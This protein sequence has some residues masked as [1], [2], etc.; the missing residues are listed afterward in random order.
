MNNAFIVL[1]LNEYRA[2]WVLRDSIAEATDVPGKGMGILQ[3]LQKF[4]V[5]VR[6]CYRTHRNSGYCG[7]AVQNSQK[8]PAGIKMMYAYPGYC[9]TGVQSFQK[10]RVRV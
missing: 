6:G 4:Q 10:F 3:N 8:F 7:T 1:N 9:G 5:R 2:T